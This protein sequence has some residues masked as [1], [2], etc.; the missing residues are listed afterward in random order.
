GDEG[1]RGKLATRLAGSSD[2]YEAGGRQPYHSINF[3][4]SHDGFTLN[5]LVSYS[6]KHNESNH[7]GNRDGDDN[8]YSCNYGVE[9]PTRR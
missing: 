9:G 2:L 8:N 3:I 4:T 1:C 5:D 7:E 6:R